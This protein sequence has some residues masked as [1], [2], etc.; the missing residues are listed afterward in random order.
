[1]KDIVT[2][3][4]EVSKELAQ[5]TYNKATGAQKNRIKKLYKAAH[6]EDLDTADNVK[7]IKGTWEEGTVE[8]HDKRV[9]IKQTSQLLSTKYNNDH[10]YTDGLFWGKKCWGFPS[11]Y[12]IG[13]LINN[14]IEDYNDP[15]LK[16]YWVDKDGKEHE[17]KED[18]DKNSAT[19]YDNPHT[20]SVIPW[21]K[22]DKQKSLEGFVKRWI[23]LQER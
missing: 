15:T 19:Y 21:K 3:I 22:V 2:Y 23:I 14:D 16:Y 12:C 1:M 9:K 20:I 8:Y 18:W 7:L 6:G 5:R 10:V 13:F 11:G 4:N 17:T